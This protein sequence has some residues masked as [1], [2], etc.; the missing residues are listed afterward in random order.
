MQLSFFFSDIFVIF[1]CKLL[2]MV[3]L[4]PLLK[5]FYSTSDVVSNGDNMG[6][7]FN[8]NFLTYT[9]E[10]CQLAAGQSVLIIPLQ[11]DKVTPWKTYKSTLFDNRFV[12]NKNARNLCFVLTNKWVFRTIPIA[13]GTMLNVLLAQPGIHHTMGYMS[14]YN[15]NR[16]KKEE[17][18]YINEPV[19]DDDDD[20]DDDNN[21]DEQPTYTHSASTSRILS[22][23]H[24]GC[25][26][27]VDI[28]RP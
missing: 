19:F 13:R 9:G 26:H 3:P 10:D 7:I 12:R 1:L 11:E 18:D 5:F 23:H 22:C 17:P 2:T 8:P 24:T 15:F 21:D 27:H 4:P 28:I 25:C 20:D 14:A 6:T 16:L